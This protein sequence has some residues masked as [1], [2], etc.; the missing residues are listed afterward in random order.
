MKLIFYSRSIFWIILRRGTKLFVC[1]LDC[2]L[3]FCS[4]VGIIGFLFLV[5]CFKV[6]M[7]SFGEGGDF[8]VICRFFFILFQVVG[9]ISVYYYWFVILLSQVV[10]CLLI[11]GLFW[12]KY[13]FFVVVLFF[14]RVF[15]IF[16]FF[17]AQFDL[18]FS[19]LFGFL[20]SF[21]G[22]QVCL[23][24]W[25]FCSFSLQLVLLLFW[26]IFFV[27]NSLL[28]KVVWGLKVSFVFFFF[29]SYLQLVGSWVF[30]LFSFLS[31]F[32][33]FVF[34]LVVLVVVR[35]LSYRFFI[36]EILF[37][38]GSDIRGRFFFVGL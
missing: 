27:F 13:W 35:V 22:F 36:P 8:G 11:L 32:P 7:D 16:L 21:V 6:F 20:F 19:F 24:F 2:N 3:C 15:V 18:L 30:C 23:V 14:L 33:F 12:L 25:S 4:M 9:L 34:C 37:Y 5:L 17:L 38:W 26:G 28:S 1:F 29:F 31:A 10:F